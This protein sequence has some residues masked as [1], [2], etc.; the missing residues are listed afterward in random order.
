[1]EKVNKLWFDYECQKKRGDIINC[2]EGKS[3]NPLDRQ[4]KQKFNQKFMSIKSCI[5]AKEPCYGTLE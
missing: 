2:S 1:M 3:S 4:L 5:K